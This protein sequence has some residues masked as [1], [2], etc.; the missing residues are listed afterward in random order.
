MFDFTYIFKIYEKED[1]WTRERKRERERVTGFCFMDGSCH[2]A[3]K[4]FGNK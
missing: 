3:A 2:N 4:I 1:N